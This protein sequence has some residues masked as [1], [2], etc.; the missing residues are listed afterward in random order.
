MPSIYPTIKIYLDTDNDGIPET[1]ISSRVVSNIDGENGIFSNRDTERLPSIGSLRFRINNADGAYTD[2]S[3]YIGK[4]VCISVV[5][6]EIE[7]NAFFGTITTFN[8]DSGEWGERK[9]DV[10]VSDWFNVA[11]KTRFS[12]QLQTFLRAN[13]G[14]ETVLATLPNPPAYQ[15]F[16][17]GYETFASL[18][19]S[20]TSKTRVYSELDKLSKSELG[21]LYLRFREKHDG[22]TIRFENYLNRGS[23]RE[24]NKIPSSI[25]NSFLKKHGASSD[26]GYLKY[27][28]VGISGK[29]RINQV[30]DASFNEIVDSDWNIAADSVIN[31]MSITIIPRNTDTVPQV[32]YTLGS[33]IES[34]TGVKRHI[35]GGY[36]DPN[37][38]TVVQAFDVVEPLGTTDY[39]FNSLED[40]TGTDLTANLFVVFN[41]TSGYFDFG[42]RNDGP[43]GYLTFLQVR[44]KGIYKYNPIELISENVESKEDIVRTEISDYMTREYSSDLNTSKLFA[45][46]VIAVNRFPN[47]TLKSVTFIANTSEKLLSAFMY[48]EQGDKVQ[49]TETVPSHTGNYYIQ[50]IRFTI[51]LDGFIYFTWY[52]KEAVETVC[53]P[54]A[55]RCGTDNVGSRN[56]INYGVL[57]QLAN[58]E[59]YSYSMWVKRLDSIAGSYAALITRSVDDGTGRRG[60]ELSLNTNGS[61]DFYSYKTPSDGHWLYT[62]LLTGTNWRH[63]V[64][65][66]D[67]TS[68]KSNPE[69]WLDGVAYTP[70]IIGTPSGSTDNDSDCPLVLFN[71]TPAPGSGNEYYSTSLHDVE[72]KDVRVYNRILASG[73]VNTLYNN[74]DDYSTV[75]SGLMFNGIYAPHDNRTDYVNDSITADDL[76]LESVHGY[77]GIPYNEITT[78]GIT[79]MLYG[80]DL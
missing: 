13:E 76:V 4:T 3:L 52:L 38:G 26:N 77:A 49:I 36:S 39:L 75:Q 15:R 29:I 57:P 6:N 80:L 14:L 27:H 34:G 23:L 33:P 41:Y 43:P 20:S 30:E 2:S 16:D 7:K 9:I 60:N 25:G 56:A 64:V 1:D 62:N 67:N 47:K 11:N 63:L 71:W 10:T 40:G 65:T 46:S 45:D 55:V 58:M 12:T 18:F 66:Y 35:V 24:I 5:Y 59:K 32:L 74:I 61:I 31:D 53:E 22:E 68:D 48:L 79:R 8:I 78:S 72:M 70:T 54:I 19:D 42:Y 28:G 73:E 51:T 44:G 17:E 37:G 50:G 21:Y 69:F